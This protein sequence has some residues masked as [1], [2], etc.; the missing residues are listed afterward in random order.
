MGVT[1]TSSQQQLNHHIRTDS[2]LSH[3]G[4]K[5][6]LLVPNLRPRFCYCEVQE[7]FSSH[8]SLLNNAIW[9]AGQF[10]KNLL[11]YRLFRQLNLMYRMHSLYTITPTG[12]SS[13]EMLGFPIVIVGPSFLFSKLKVIVPLAVS[14]VLSVTIKSIVSPLV[15]ARAS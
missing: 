13:A 2:S 14:P 15:V 7:M 9:S 3:G 10:N 8:G 4:L 1:K 11:E 6:I 12:P 5:C